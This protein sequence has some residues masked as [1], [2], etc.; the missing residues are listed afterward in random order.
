MAAII[1]DDFRKSLAKQV[2]AD[3][4]D[5]AKDNLYIGI[6]KSDPWKNTIAEEAVAG[7][8]PP[9]PNGSMEEKDEVIEN[10]M[11]LIKVSRTSRV[12]PRVNYTQGKIYK[13]YDANDP[14][15]FLPTTSGGST[16]EPSYAVQTVGGQEKLF[17]CLRNNFGAQT[18]TNDAPTV[19]G[20]GSEYA[21]VGGGDTS[22]STEL[23][24]NYQWAYV[25]DVA[26]ATT[27]FNTSQFI[28]VSTSNLVEGANNDA[29]AASNETG[30]RIYALK[31]ISGG[32]GYND[33]S[34]TITIIGEGGTEYPITAARII[35]PTGV[36]EQVDFEV[37]D[38]DG[39]TFG[40]SDWTHCSV[41]VNSSSGSG[42]EIIALK[43]PANGFGFN[44][45]SDLP[46]YYV[47]LESS[48]VGTLE[49]DAPAIAYRQISLLKGLPSGS[50]SLYSNDSPDD[51]NDGSVY[52][53]TDTLDALRYL[54]LNTGTLNGVSITPGDVLFQTSNQATGEIPAAAFVDYIEQ[55][56]AVGSVAA[57]DRIYFHQNNSTI[58]NTKAFDTNGSGGDTV[59]IQSRANFIAGNSTYISSGLTYTTEGP[60]GAEY[61]RGKGEIVFYENRTAINRSAQQTEDV[62][63]VVQL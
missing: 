21:L 17:I 24:H 20:S 8:S 3:H 11:A 47:G 54:K 37:A 50:D 58:I 9:I 34:D 16:L 59:T 41:R 38:V 28:E 51:V 53:P 29:T 14:T 19:A 2:I 36:I 13:Q 39:H 55:R 7:F 15:T 48:L 35:A 62:K 23:S 10:L 61:V 42:A 57:H 52:A 44:L 56:S 40:G 33:A 12:I 25:G 45:A 22:S 5:S 30:G 49:G 32:T 43:G 27:N 46:S 63:I 1:T 26:D 60:Q 6:G 4:A 31:I 18:T